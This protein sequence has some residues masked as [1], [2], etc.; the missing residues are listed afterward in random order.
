M[1]LAQ[2]TQSLI[3]LH[4][5]ANVD[6]QS[7][8]HLIIHIRDTFDAMFEFHI[9]SVTVL[10]D[11]STLSDFIDAL[12]NTTDRLSSDPIFRLLMSD[13]QNIVGQMVTSLSQVFNEMHEQF[14]QSAVQGNDFLSTLNEIN[15]GLFSDGISLV[16]MLFTSLNNPLFDQ[17]RFKEELNK[18]AHVREYLLTLISNLSMNT[19]TDIIFYSSILAK[20]TEIPHQ[21]TIKASVDDQSSFCSSSFSLFLAYCIKPI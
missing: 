8:I 12:T 13:D 19:S 9:P 6:P 1:M 10:A 7:T 14:I 3:Q 16:D 15:V 11:S 4:L 18:H 21:L 5:P 17:I 2:S 20:L